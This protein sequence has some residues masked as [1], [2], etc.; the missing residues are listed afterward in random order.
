MDEADL[1]ALNQILDVPLRELTRFLFYSTFTRMG[2]PLFW[3]QQKWDETVNDHDRY[4]R[5]EN[6]ADFARDY[7]QLKWTAGDANG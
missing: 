1:A 7:M 5:W 4:T 2:R 3:I 6:E